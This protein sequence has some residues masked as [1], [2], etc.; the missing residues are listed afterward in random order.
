MR[1]LAPV[2]RAGSP[3]AF[4]LAGLCLLLPFITISCSGEDNGQS[5]R[6]SVSYTGVDLLV[7]GRM[8]VF[9]EVSDEHGVVQRIDLDD[10]DRSPMGGEVPSIPHQTGIAVGLG[11]L[12]LG[13]LLV[14]LPHPG[15]RRLLVAGVAVAAGV[16]LFVGGLT[17]R[18]AMAGMLTEV[19][20][21]SA[22]RVRGRIGYGLGFWLAVG[23][24]AVV[25]AVN[26]VGAFRVARPPA[27]PAAPESAGELNPV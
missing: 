8:D 17:G 10:V 22:Q 6:G 4:V 16:S 24:L 11:L 18:A 1:R 12:G 27:V 20:A 23:L 7:G 21:E 19:F 13:V 15:W 5:L 26:L 9:A 2:G 14:L 3:L 25:V